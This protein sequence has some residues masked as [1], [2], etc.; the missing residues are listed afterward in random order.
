[1]DI[2]DLRSRAEAIVKAFRNCDRN[3]TLALS[4]F[5]TLAAE[6]GPIRLRLV[7]DWGRLQA[8]ISEAKLTPADV[9]SPED[10][11]YLLA[12]IRSE[13]GAAESRQVEHPALSYFLELGVD[14]NRLPTK[15][16]RKAS[17]MPLENWP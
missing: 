16:K 15:T 7:R 6:S 5:G 12:S 1:M 2:A 11:R 8:E 10:L 3:D 14:V 13:Q 4:K 17:V 9:L